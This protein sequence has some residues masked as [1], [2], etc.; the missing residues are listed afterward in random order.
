MLVSHHFSH[1]L[2]LPFAEINKS[3]GT[4]D[5]PGEERDM[6]ECQRPEGESKVEAAAASEESSAVSHGQDN[7]KE[8][9]TSSS[10]DTDSPVMINVDVSL[11][12]KM[13]RSVQD[14]F[15]YP[16]ES[17]VTHQ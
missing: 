11:R 16:S 6:T 13:R 3:V 10:P 17:T 5:S 7:P 14:I 9:T 4:V 1:K 2:F 15:I 12:L 8:P